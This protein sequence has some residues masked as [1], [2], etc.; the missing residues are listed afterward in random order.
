MGVPG[1][2]N[3]VA[4]FSSPNLKTNIL[5]PYKTLNDHIVKNDQTSVPKNI[6]VEALQS[7]LQEQVYGQTAA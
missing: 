1:N 4:M 6:M 5:Y 7:F 3:Y 2:S